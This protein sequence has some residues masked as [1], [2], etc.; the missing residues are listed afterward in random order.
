MSRR[1]LATCSLVAAIA[2]TTGCGSPPPPDERA[3]AETVVETSEVRTP[4]V[5]DDSGRPPVTFDPCLDLPDDV[6]TEAGYN[7][8]HKE[9]SD[10]PMGSYT[11]LGC[12][13]R[14]SDPIP[15]VRRGYSLSVLAGNVSLDEE[16][17]KN[18]HVATATTVNGRTALLE[19]D[20]SIKDA[21]TYVLQ[22]TFGIVIFSRLY[23]KDHAGAVPQ[24]EWCA[25]MEPLVR[26][27]EPF[28]GS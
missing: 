3:R 9:F 27:A 28:I 26:A 19:L 13:Y 16:I 22:S 11:F 21:C 17:A 6:M 24:N 8:A 5:V 7:A 25:D 2:V 18:G 4:R 14:K 23:N 20:P 10:M 15:G 12:T 1:G